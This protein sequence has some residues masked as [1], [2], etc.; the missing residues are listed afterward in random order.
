MTDTTTPS[1]PGGRRLKI[2][3]VSTYDELC[4]IAGYTR[5]LER[6]LGGHADVEV[7]DL[8]QYLLRNTHRRVQKMADRH[9][10][11]IASRLSAFDSVNIQ[12]EHGT[13]GRT[14]AQIIRRFKVLVAAAPCLSVTFHTI[15][16]DDP[17]PWDLVGRLLGR[18]N[19]GGALRTIGDNRRAHILSG[20]I[21]RAMRRM[22]RTKQVR[23]IV[24]TKRD[25]RLLRHV[26]GLRE[27]S[28]HPLSYVDAARAAEIRA[29]ASRLMFPTL[30]NVPEGAKLMGTFGFLSP[31]KGFETAVEA[32]RYLPEDHHLLVFGGVHPQTIRR[33]LAI[34]PYIARLLRKAR[35]GETLLDQVRESG[36]SLQISSD[37]G[38]AELLRRHPQDL[39]GRVHFMG[40]LPDE[41]FLSAMALCDCV[42]LPYL[43]VGQSA[44]GPIA[45]ALEMG[46]RVIASRTAAFLQFNRYH[47]GHVENFDIGNYAELAERV[48]SESQADCSARVLAFNSETN[49]ALYLEANTPPSRGHA[50]RAAVASIKGAFE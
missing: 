9:V 23:T 13:L 3:V 24:H 8:D 26:H 30:A 6:Q 44:S 43:E 1:R 11:D 41:G 33:E 31:Y 35:I 47:P 50:F 25:M 12:L 4:G 16:T 22:Q 46:C 40:V 14:A 32:L 37:A 5:A 28:H 7:F 34:D 38:A 17:V 42:A 36:A 19:V 20:G 49:T 2:A 10:R 21:Y 45:M 15:L 27:V 48:R 29:G 18:G 39:S